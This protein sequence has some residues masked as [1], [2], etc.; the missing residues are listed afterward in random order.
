MLINISSQVLQKQVF[1]LPL[2]SATAGTSLTM[3][4]VFL[5]TTNDRH[6]LSKNLRAGQI[7]FIDR[8]SSSCFL[9]FIAPVCLCF[10]PP[11]YLR[12]CLCV[13][14]FCFIC[15]LNHICMFLKPRSEKEKHACGKV[16]LLTGPQTRSAKLPIT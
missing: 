15:L 10:H 16:E 8:A 4:C 2:S 13:F 3:L 9:D 5:P 7:S 11:C 12:K 1:D 14:I 6:L